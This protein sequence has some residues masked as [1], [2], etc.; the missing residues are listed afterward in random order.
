VKATANTT[1]LSSFTYNYQKS[2]ADTDL[3]QSMTDPTGT[4]SYSYD[5][6]NRLTDGA[7]LKLPRPAH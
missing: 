6:L 2:G 4:T 1:T 5:G 7:Q 3:R